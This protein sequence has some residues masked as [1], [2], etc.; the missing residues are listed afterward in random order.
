MIAGAM[1]FIAAVALAALGGGLIPQGKRQAAARKD[2]KRVEAKAAGAPAGREL[3]TFAGG[4]F[5]CTEA[6][7]KDLKGVDKVVSGYTGGRTEN[8]TY[9]EVCSGTTG[10]AEAIQITYDPKVVSYR[11]LVRIFLATHDPTTLNR[12]G[13]DSGTQYRS[14]IFYHGD[15]QKAAAN[16]VIQE[17][18]KA[19]IWSNKIVTEVVPAAKYYP[20]EDYHQDYYAQNPNAGYC[21]V[22]IEPK[23]AK[24]RAKYR[25]KLKR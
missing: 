22:V 21:R 5:W 1:A 11:D 10:H 24:F 13:A 23:V 19:G 15:A 25:D 18:Q 4:C 6:F 3:A 7:F 20:A 17:V 2:K 14:A 8:P 16:E 9:E 12:Q